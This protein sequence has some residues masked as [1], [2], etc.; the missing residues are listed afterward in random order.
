MAKIVPKGYADIGAYNEMDDYTQIMD[1]L[2]GVSQDVRAVKREKESNNIQSLSL[3]NNLIDNAKDSNDI[4]Q[5]RNIYKQNFDD[6]FQ[7]SNPNYNTLVDISNMALENRSTQI[8]DFEGSSQEFADMLYS[9]DNEFNTNIL[10]LGAEEVEGLFSKMNKDEL[11]GWMDTALD[12]RDNIVRY[13]A[14]I[15]DLYGNK[16]PNFKIMVNG[17]KRSIVEVMQNLDRFDQ[18]IDVLVNKALDDGILS[19]QEAQAIATIRPS[20]GK[21]SAQIKKL[22]EGKRKLGRQMI[23]DGDKLINSRTMSNLQKVIKEGG[24][25]RAQIPS[26]FQNEFEADIAEKHIP[27]L[28]QV[29]DQNGNI[30]PAITGIMSREEKVE[31]LMKHLE[32]GSIDQTTLLAFA[33]NTLEEG[34]RMSQGGYRMLKAYGGLEDVLG[35]VDLELETDAYFKNITLNPVDAPDADG[36]G[37]P[38]Y[39]DPESANKLP[40]GAAKK[41]TKE[42]GVS[43]DKAIPKYEDLSDSEKRKIEPLRKQ[44]IKENPRLQGDAGI[45]STEKFYNSLNRSDEMPEMKKIKNIIKFLTTPPKE[46]AFTGKPYNELSEE[47]K[48][49]IKQYKLSV[50]DKLLIR[51][52]D[53]KFYNTLSEKELNKILK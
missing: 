11:G 35:P 16:N 28:E 46:K 44:S 51:L 30:I 34:S 21:G 2:R 32:A 52:S 25:I 24:D 22:F 18:T 6:K 33:K 41:D 13:K 1:F 8:S 4:Q 39:L 3:I 5:I 48:K 31:T 19:P 49:R 12:T 43:T 45:D 42:K 27:M 20:Q 40:A 26:I 17:Q 10:N 15:K 47:N 50:G 7:S 38:D 23:Q 14:S 9:T 36:D 53:S 37:V 29:T